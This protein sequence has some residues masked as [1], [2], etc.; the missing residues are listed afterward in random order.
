MWTPPATW[1]AHAPRTY[2]WSGRPAVLQTMFAKL[3]NIELS[4]MIANAR[5]DHQPDAREIAK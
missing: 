4:A 3:K 1:L 5:A 2:M